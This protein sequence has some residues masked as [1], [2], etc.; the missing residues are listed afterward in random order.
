MTL[1]ATV[2][3]RPLQPPAE[4]FSLICPGCGHRNWSCDGDSLRCSTCH[5]HYALRGNVVDLLSDRQPEPNPVTNEW[6]RYYGAARPPYNPDQEWWKIWAWKKHL[7]G[8]VAKGL[9]GKLVLDLGCGNAMR[10]AAIA[11]IQKHAYRYIGVDSSLDALREAAGNLPGGWLVRADLGSFRWQ[12]ASVDIALCLGL[13]MYFEDYRPLL[14]QLLAA[15]KPGGVLLLHEFCRKAS[16]GSRVRRWFPLQPGVFANHTVY[17]VSERELRAELRT[18][19]TILHL[20]RGGSPWRQLM[21]RALD[22][23]WLKACRP[24]AALADSAWCISVGRLW[25]AIGAAEL[26]IVFRKA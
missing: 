10:L 23:S 11:P 12:P 15:L 16:W 3:V 6:D 14:R 8:S 7:F 5:S 17:Q 13:L 19:G 4:L 1:P 24:V 26:Q 18:Q 9:A 21:M 22:R 2:I 25:P 20:H